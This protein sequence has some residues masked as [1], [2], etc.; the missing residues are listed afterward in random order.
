MKENW[1]YK[2]LGE[3]AQS[4]LGKTLNS[5]KDKGTL[6]PYLCAIN[7][8]WDKIDTSTLK[9]TRF[10]EAELERYSV[11]KGDL[12]VCEGGEIGRAAIWNEDKTIQYQ[13]ALHRLRFNG[14]I[15]PRFCLMYLRSLKDRGI[16]DG[17]YGKG[18][19]I[20]HLVKSALLSIPIPVPPLAEQE[21]IAAELDLISS[22]IEKKK[23]QLKE[24]DNLAQS[25]FYQMFGDPV[26][27]EKGWEVKLLKEL[28]SFK[29]GLNYHPSDNGEVVK[30]IGVGDFRDRREI[31]DF[32]NIP[33]LTINESV[34]KDYFLKNG[35]IIIVRSNGSKELVGRNMIVFPNNENITYSGF[36][37]RCRISDTS[38]SD[39]LLLPIILNRILSNRSIMSVLRQEGRGC[40]IS[41]I[42][43]K[44]LSSLPVPIPPLSLQ[45]LFA[46]KIESIEKQKALIQQSISEMETLFKSRMDAY[47][48]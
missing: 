29:N 46:E 31:K 47:F 4:E 36:C 9:E 11:K 22:I 18:V 39:T 33:S 44:I 40:N 13:N 45:Q 35:D 43:Q 28:A 14:E 27:N 25:I 5:S 12:L 26:T 2:K 38:P 41:N 32:T 16:L 20:K 17:R 21:H 15:L 24:L 48:D 6:Y 7:V 34:D 23:Q 10:E 3:V 19:T 37:I 30:C 1:E 42:N 8:L